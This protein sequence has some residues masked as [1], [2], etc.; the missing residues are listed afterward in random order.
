MTADMKTFGVLAAALLLSAGPAHA[1]AAAPAVPSDP[2]RAAMPLEAF[3]PELASHTAVYDIALTRAAQ[4]NGVRGATGRLTYTF[5]D[6]C[7]GYTVESEFN[8]DIAYSSGL[9][10]HVVQ[11]Y[12]GWESKDGRRSTF[13]MS[14][15]DNDE[16]E[17]S[18]TGSVELAPD[19][20]GR[21]V[22]RGGDTVTYA[23]P[24]GTLLS[25]AHLQH[26]IRVGRSQSGVVADTVMDGAFD[27]GP[28]RVT[29]FVG[30]MRAATAET[31]ELQ[32]RATPSDRELLR[33][34]YWPVGLAYFPLGKAA[35]TP[36]Y[37]LSLQ[38]Q[39]NGIV[40]AMTQDFV[41]YTLSFDLAAIRAL[42]RGC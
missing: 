16:L 11:R 35:E 38:V 17:D 7:D 31:L 9:T 28:H 34:G 21:A 18:Y 26:L 19:L 1:A 24:A 10:S 42:P 2:A 22:Y 25:T 41:T 13:R 14:V 39:G 4:T 29:G 23:L 32:V 37:E 36:D 20:S 12:A 3:E 6:Q 30:P 33:G 8:A 5:Q 40:R 27:Q 15:Y